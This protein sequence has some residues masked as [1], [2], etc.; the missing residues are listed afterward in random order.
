[1]IVA[2]VWPQDNSTAPHPW[3]MPS[4]AARPEKSF[5]GRQVSFQVQAHF[6]EV[7]SP[8]WSR[9]LNGPRLTGLAHPAKSSKGSGVNCGGAHSGVPTTEVSNCRLP[10]DWRMTSRLYPS[11]LGQIAN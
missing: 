9:L 3:T 11:P 4:R 5:L 1:M 6:R 7:D 2:V 10:K 8:S